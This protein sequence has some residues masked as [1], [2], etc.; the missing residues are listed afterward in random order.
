[1]VER[2]DDGFYYFC[3]IYKCDKTVKE[4]LDDGNFRIVFYLK[5]INLS[6]D[7][8]LKFSGK[9]LTTIH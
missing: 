9:V 8:S 7:D 2:K 1:L 3:G 5:S 6:V 4:K